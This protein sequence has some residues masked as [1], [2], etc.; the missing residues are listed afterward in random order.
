MALGS[1]V[2]AVCLASCHHKWHCPL[3]PLAA[4][5]PLK[6]AKQDLGAMKAAMAR[7]QAGPQAYA[8]MHVPDPGQV[9]WCSCCLA[10][11]ERYVVFAVCCLGEG[12]RPVWDQCL[13]Q[14]PLAVLHARL[15]LAPPP[16][17][18]MHAF[19]GCNC[20]LHVPGCLACR[21]RSSGAPSGKYSCRRP[22]MGQR[23]VPGSSRH[24]FAASRCLPPPQLPPPCT[25]ISL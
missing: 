19:P 11:R 10:G 12:R 21:P 13:Q 7:Q 17:S 4:C 18:A 14:A 5:R 6:A 9:S 16:R 20:A 3:L 23:C 24:P 22:P 2:L 15:L 8:S 1:P 25:G